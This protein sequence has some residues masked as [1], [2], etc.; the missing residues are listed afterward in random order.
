[1]A[2]THN[3]E[4]LRNITMLTDLPPW[5]LEVVAEAVEHVEVGKGTLI[6]ERGSDDGYTYFLRE[7]EV[8]GVTCFFFVAE[9]EEC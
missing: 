2:S 4:A 9:H 7:G 8:S 6:V 5:Q 1:M 3:T